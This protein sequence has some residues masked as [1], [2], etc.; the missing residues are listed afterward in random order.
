MKTVSVYYIIG[1]LVFITLGDNVRV[2]QLVISA[3]LLSA[4]LSDVTT[5]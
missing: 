5:S 4:R 3:P 2:R 1:L